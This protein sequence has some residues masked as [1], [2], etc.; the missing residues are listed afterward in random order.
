MAL[1][2]SVEVTT[3]PGSRGTL[4]RRSHQQSRGAVLLLICQLNACASP[5]DTSPAETGRER[6]QRKARTSRQ[7]SVPFCGCVPAGNVSGA[8]LQWG[9]HDGAA[10]DDRVR[11]GLWSRSG[12]SSPGGSWAAAPSPS[13]VGSR[14]V[15]VLVDK[16]VTWQKGGSRR[17]GTRGAWGRML[18]SSQRS[19]TFQNPAT[20]VFSMISVEAAAVPAMHLPSGHPEGC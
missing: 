20:R 19:G 6:V 10:P 9:L 15:P 8:G 5:L 1:K 4:E 7:D 3:A 12:Q 18:L 17:R 14:T 11:R 16:T 13:Q 2:G